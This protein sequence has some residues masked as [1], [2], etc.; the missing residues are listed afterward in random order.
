MES[1]EV[2]EE[3][4]NHEEADT[5]LIYL[6]LQNKADRVIVS[7]DT[8]VFVLLVWAYTK[9]EIKKKWYMMYEQGKYADIG[10]IV[11]SFGKKF[12]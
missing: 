1:G 2:L 5:R 3:E 12:V 10:K 6:A 11:E 4:C 9:H 7:K 8:D